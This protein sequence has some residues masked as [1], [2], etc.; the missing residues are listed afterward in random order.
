MRGWRA[1]ASR[2]KGMLCLVML[3]AAIL[4]GLHLTRQA[5]A[6][7]RPVMGIVSTSAEDDRRDAQAAALV[8]AAE[9][10]GFD[11]LSMPAERTQDAQI[12]AIRALIVYRADVIVFTPLVESGWNNV[13]REA[14]AAGIP[15]LAVDKSM[16]QEIEGQKSRYVGYDYSALAAQATDALLRQGQSRQGVIELYG[17]LNSYD[18]KEIARGCRETLDRAG[19]T[20]TYSLCG[21]GM[22]SRGYEIMESLQ[23]HLD[24]T[25]Y[26][27]CHNDAMA[28]GALDYLE[29]HGRVPGQDI[30]L[31]AI[32]GGEEAYRA[33]E[34]GR[35][36]VLVR[37]DDQALA[38]NTVLA[39]REAMDA[40]REHLVHL[41]QGQVM[42]KENG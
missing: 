1:E 9:Q 6:P 5:Q 10:D 26:V 23:I 36:Q 24:E 4:L 25:G 38:A 34:D 13:V 16:Q 8:Q 40:P 41:A 2:I 33:F 37:L 42:E 21:D 11:V 31:C 30:A 19:K 18:A 39:A 22:R 28:L 3:T 29:E 17:T 14:H 7:H 27:I 32:G 35:I 20:I 12:E 15:L